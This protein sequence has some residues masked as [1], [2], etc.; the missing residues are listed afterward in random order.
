MSERTAPHTN[1][2]N[3]RAW[4]SMTWAALDEFGDHGDFARQHLLT[5]ALLDLCGDVSGAQV[6]DAGAGNGYLSR[7]LA[8]MGAGVT[9][10]EPADAP[11]RYILER[12]TAAPLGITC[13]QED[14]SAITQF[15][16]SFDL[17]VANMVLLDIPDFR[18]AIANCLHALRAGGSFVFSL[19]HP[20]TDV[21]ERS[22]LFLK[23]DDYFTERARERRIA[24][25]F[26]RTL[27]TY[28]DVLADCGALVERIKEPRLP[29]ELAE[30][31]LEHAWAHRLPAF[32][33]IKAVKAGDAAKTLKRVSEGHA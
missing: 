3:I 14:L 4:S 19:E 17:V 26:H 30:L 1:A 28:V 8:G 20:F 11:F 2:D 33:V 15:D 23:V 21:A 31:Y 5:P 32:I 7:L 10:L 18:T 12:E 22:E 25:N 16:G 13:L 27:E 9:A 29:V 6:L 24:H